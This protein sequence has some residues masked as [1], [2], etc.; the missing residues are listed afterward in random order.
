MV[1][2][3]LV[4]GTLVSHQGATGHYQVRASRIQSLVD[5]EILLFPTKINLYFLHIIVEE[6]ANLG[7]SLVDGMQR[8]EQWS[9]IVESLTGV[10][11][12]DSRDT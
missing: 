5:Q 1:V 12:E 3:L 2:H 8:T 6:L 7:S 4:L 11:N 9:L 10:G